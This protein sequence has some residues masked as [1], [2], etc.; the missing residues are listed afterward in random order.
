MNLKRMS[1]VR[2]Y[3][4]AICFGFLLIAFSNQA[5]AQG[6]WETKDPMPT[7]RYGSAAGVIGGKLYVASGCC[8]SP[9]FPNP[10]F[11]VLEVYDPNTD[12]WTTKAPI[13]TGVYGAAVGVIDGKLYVAGG[14]AIVSE[15]FNIAT[16]QVY[17][18]ATDTWTTKAPMPFGSV[19]MA[20]GV[21]DGKLYVAGGMTPP[22][23]GTVDTL[24]V[25]DPVADTWSIKVPMPTARMADGGVVNGILY[26]VGGFSGSILNLVEAYDPATNTWDTTMAPMPTPRYFFSVG[27]LDGQIHT[28]GGQDCCVALDAHEVYNP[29]T[30]TWT[31]DTSLLP[32][33]ILPAVGVVN[34]ILYAAGGTTDGISHLNVLEAFPGPISNL[35]TTVTVLGFQQGVKLL[36]NAEGQ[37][38]AGNLGA[39]CNQL[40]AFIKQVKTQSGK[41]LTADEADQLIASA[42]QIKAALGCP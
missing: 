42:N 1:R 23:T 40:S 18:P 25:Y 13:P 8:I 26:V 2:N 20:A 12:T 5:F 35:T 9:H 4:V 36:A 15:G 39:G 6:T 32:A 34:G 16:L 28:V 24:R 22:N 3:T 11:T 27:V 21:I 30:D 29:T 19:G 38:N 33:R 31:T 41:Q 14:Q 10:R 7:A 17:D 37:I